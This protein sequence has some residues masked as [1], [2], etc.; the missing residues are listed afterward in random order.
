M[1]ILTCKTTENRTTESVPVEERM[2][3]YVCEPTLFLKYLELLSNL[4]L[5]IKTVEATL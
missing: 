3:E 4:E 2:A 5:N 1:L